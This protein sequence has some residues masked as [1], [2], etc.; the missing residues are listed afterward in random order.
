MCGLIMSI[1]LVG[2]SLAPKPISAAA[3]GAGTSGTGTWSRPKRIAQ[4]EPLF[5]SCP[6]ANFCV[7]VDGGGNALTYNGKTWSAPKLISKSGYLDAVSCPS[8]SF[9]VA[10]SPNGYAVTY[11]GKDWSAPKLI[12]SLVIP[13]SVSCPS[14]SFCVAVGSGYAV[15]YNGKSWSPQ[16]HIDSN[17]FP[18]PESVSCVSASFCVAVDGGGNALTYN[19]K[20]WS[21]PRVIDSNKNLESVSC[22]SAIFCVAVGDNGYAL[23]YAGIPGVVEYDSPYGSASWIGYAQV[24]PKGIKYTSVEATFK[25]PKVT[26]LDA[27]CP[28]HLTGNISPCFQLSIWVGIG[29]Y[30]KRDHLIQV[31]IYLNMPGRGGK[32]DLNAFT[33]TVGMNTPCPGSSPTQN[34]CSFTDLTIHQG[35]TITASV[36]QMSTNIWRMKI[37][38]LTTGK[39]P[40]PRDATFTSFYES[41]E[42]VAERV[43][44]G[45]TAADTGPAL[46]PTTNIVFDH[47]DYGD[48]GKAAWHPFFKAPM[49]ATM[50][51]IPMT[52]A[53]AKLSSYGTAT[54]SAPNSATDGFQVADGTAIPPTPSS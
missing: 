37:Q 12:D 20:T 1:S 2:A 16:K 41:A 27:K 45:G 24:A 50:Y 33:E 28:P 43:S 5:V 49:G 34:P 23:T 21:A 53:A 15:T 18:L 11:N 40:L 9:C 8:A 48:N 44:G 32:V 6:S 14:V 52:Q 30:N 36:T 19:G 25:I 26:N 46:P 35:D 4:F 47:A 17:P 10:V 38:D 3:S 42:A 7:A 22:P 51:W 29:G 31:G 54:P 39:S 13:E